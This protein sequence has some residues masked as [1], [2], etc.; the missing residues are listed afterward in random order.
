[1]KNG[2]CVWGTKLR[3]LPELACFANATAT[4]ALDFNDTYLS[5]EPAHPSDNAAAVLAVAE[6]TGADGRAFLTALVLAYEVQCRLC[7]GASLRAR[8]FDHV[9]YGLFSTAAAAGKLLGLSVE[10]IAHALSIVGVGGIA[11]RQ[12][13]SGEISM[14]KAS[15]FAQAARNGLFAARLAKAG[16]TGPAELFEGPF[17]FFRLVSGPLDAEKLFNKEADFRI[18]RA[19]LKKYPAE[20]HGQSAVEAALALHKQTGGADSIDAVD[21]ET[22]QAAYEIIGKDSEKWHPKTRETADHSLPYLVATALLDG[23]LTLDSFRPERF[24]DPRRV[25]LMSRIHIR[26]RADFSDAYPEELHTAVTVKT[27]RG[28]RF[29]EEVSEPRGHFKNPMSDAEIEEKFRLLTDGKLPKARVK[30]LLDRIWHVEELKN[31]SELTKL[32]G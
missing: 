9:N 27:K 18:L 30:A 12:T 17:G 21:V 2:A 23:T 11:L 28:E 24:Q 8:G 7:D 14:W 26:K 13:R 6:A 29:R 10:Q 4:R 1:M 25:E 16:M 20:Y 31:I 3:T 22:F 19:S 5:K 32:L 15:A